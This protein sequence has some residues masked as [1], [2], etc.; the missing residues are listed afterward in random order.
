M[1]S[2]VKGYCRPALALMLGVV[3]LSACTPKNMETTP[4]EVE[5]AK[6]TVICQLYTR[7]M[8]YWDRSIHRPEGMTADH[9][10]AVC[11]AKGHELQQA[12][13]G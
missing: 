13:A 2:T 10:D 3:F 12:R 4:V 8:V 11:A 6:G 5:T 1:I 7:N 9:A